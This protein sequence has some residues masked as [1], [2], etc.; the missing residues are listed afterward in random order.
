VLVLVYLN[1]I[2]YKKEPFEYMC[3]ITQDV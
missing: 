3:I 2:K 1:S